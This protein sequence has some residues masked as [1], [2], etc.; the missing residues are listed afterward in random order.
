M[1]ELDDSDA[2]YTARLLDELDA[3]RKWGGY[4][5]AWCVKP[6]DRIDGAAKAF[7]PAP[8]PCERDVNGRATDDGEC[9][10]TEAPQPTTAS[11]RTIRTWGGMVVPYM[12]PVAP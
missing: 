5:V 6:P 1:A 11:T 2:L 8:E 10:M 9:A 4:V 3:Y 12:W 7:R